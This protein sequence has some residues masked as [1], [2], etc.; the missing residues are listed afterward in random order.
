[1]RRGALITAALAQSRVA[2]LLGVVCVASTLARAQT[3]APPPAPEAHARDYTVPSGA[4]LRITL[5]KPV[6]LSGLHPGSELHGTISEPIYVVD[7]QVV[8]AGAPVHL[9]IDS[10]E[11]IKPGQHGLSKAI[12]EVQSLGF[13]QHFDYNVKFRSVTLALAGAGSRP[14]NVKMIEAGDV[15]RL[16]SKNGQLQVGD[17]TGAQLAGVA[18]GVGKVKNAEKDV[19]TAKHL[20][21]PGMTVQLESPLVVSLPEVPQAAS[22][23]DLG[24][25]V[26]LP[27]GTRARLL[28][29]E[30][31]DAEKN[32]DGDGFSARLLEPVAVGGQLA[33]PEGTLLGG[34]VRKITPPRRLSRSASLYFTIDHL[35]LPTGAS[36]DV[37]ASLAATEVDHRRPMSIDSEGGLHG[38]RSGAKHVAGAL[39]LAAGADMGT[40]EA[41]ELAIHALAPYAGAGV[42][43]ATL[44]LRHG[45]DVVLPQ[46]SELEVVF[47][48]PITLG[49]AANPSAPPRPPSP[50]PEKP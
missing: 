22:A 8:P 25:P 13:S 3:Q 31:L 17:S 39:L 42:G 49:G 19:K 28:L 16:E 36:Q 6:H 41:V 9:V 33:L 43:V 27:S 23:A 35:I 7:R 48:R 30:R 2:L 20:R 50:A 1:M 18:P 5:S 12:T 44:V 29:L 47:N 4:I 15:V 14:I 34:T 21:H 24:K 45:N 37:S 10:V 11:K 32:H 40:D 46:Y 38:N 26:T